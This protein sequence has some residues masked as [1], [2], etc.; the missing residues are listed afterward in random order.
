MGRCRA[1]IQAVSRFPHLRGSAM[2]L[3]VPLLVLPLAR[4]R[5]G[6]DVGRGLQAAGWGRRGAGGARGG[7][8]RGKTPSLDGRARPMDMDGDGCSV[9]NGSPRRARARR[10]CRRQDQQASL[11]PCSPSTNR[12]GTRDRE[13]SDSDSRP[14]DEDD[15]DHRREGRAECRAGTTR[16]HGGLPAPVRGL[17]A[18]GAP[19]PPSALRGRPGR[20]GAARQRPGAVAGGLQSGG[21]AASAAAARV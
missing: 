20:P 7:A 1:A 3:L 4:W 10:E 19:P 14:L 6:G 15:V 5:G 21:P 12:V 8:A 18:P 17:A 11:S 16:Q 13:C 9:L 2:P